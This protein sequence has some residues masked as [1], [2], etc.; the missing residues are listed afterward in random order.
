[1]LLKSCLASSVLVKAVLLSL[2]FVCFGRV[3]AG[4]EA[5]A[6]AL[7][8]HESPNKLDVSLDSLIVLP[9]GWETPSLENFWPDSFLRYQ[10]R[11]GLTGELVRSVSLLMRLTTS[12]NEMHWQTLWTLSVRPFALVEWRRFCSNALEIR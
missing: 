9:E 4:S 11:T 2:A 3:F 8:S 10:N 12:I 6:L 5:E 7:N 1:M